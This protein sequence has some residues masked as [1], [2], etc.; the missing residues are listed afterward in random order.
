[1]LICNDRV[2]F[3]SVRYP[4][5]S[6][7]KLD[8]IRC[9]VIEG[10]LLS[11]SGKYIPN[12]TLQT[13]FADV[14][15]FSKERELVF[16]CEIYCQDLPFQEHQSIIMSYNIPTHGRFDL[17]C[18]ECMTLKEWNTYSRPFEQNVTLTWRLS[19]LRAIPQE[20]VEIPEAAA[21]LHNEYLKLGYE[22]S[23]LRN[24]KYPYKHNR[25]TKKE[26]WAYK[27]KE[28]IDYDA[29]IL[30]CIPMKQLRTG[31]ERSLNA[32]GNLERTYKD[33]D[34]ETVPI[35]G[36]FRVQLT[37][38]T[39]CNIGTWKGLTAVERVNLWNQ[40]DSLKGRN[41]TFTGQHCGVKD[42]P[43]TPRDLRFV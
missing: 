29:V 28:L 34:Y 21:S 31:V 42:A 33:A 35:L 22:G 1:M 4:M 41:I 7:P 24:P 20:W 25:T 11:R 8:G 5:Y 3:D 37:D 15:N 9:L 12:K 23:I 17:W 32:F 18:I 16:D 39:E 10:E 6:S 36:A 43:R 2:E 19:K 26:N 27:Y 14:I 13:D 38:G 40:R 30:E